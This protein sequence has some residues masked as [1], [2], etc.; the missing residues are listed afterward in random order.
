MIYIYEKNKVLI[1]TY[2]RHETTK[3]QTLLKQAN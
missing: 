3:S 2:K 1:V